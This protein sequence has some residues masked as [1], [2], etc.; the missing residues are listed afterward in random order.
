MIWT[1]ESDFWAGMC[2]VQPQM[3]KEINPNRV[4]AAMTLRHEAVPSIIVLPAAIA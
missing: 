1:I 4:S 2:W 3:M